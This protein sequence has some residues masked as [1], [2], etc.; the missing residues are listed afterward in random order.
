[1]KKIRDVSYAVLNNYLAKQIIDGVIDWESVMGVVSK[2]NGFLSE[3]GFTNN[4]VLIPN[5]KVVKTWGLNE[6]P[7]KND[8]QK[9]QMFSNGNCKIMYHGK[10]VPARTLSKVTGYTVNTIYTYWYKCNKDTDKF[11]DFMDS[12]ILPEVKLRLL[13]GD[14]DFEFDNSDIMF[15]D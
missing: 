6:I 14:T 15:L 3:G 1:M 4:I 5:D 12:K 9:E 8:L 7:F 13:N 2:N 10:V 11:S